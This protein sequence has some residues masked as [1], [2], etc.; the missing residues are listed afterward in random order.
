MLNDASLTKK[1]NQNEMWMLTDEQFRG[2]NG[3][4]GSDGKVGLGGL[5]GL[6]ALSCFKL[7][8][9]KLLGINFQDRYCLK[10]SRHLQ[11]EK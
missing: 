3:D 1:H 5:T 9:L 11:L 6:T 10:Y 8:P 2:P 4:K 7:C